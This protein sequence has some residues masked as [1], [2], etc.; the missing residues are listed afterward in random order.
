MGKGKSTVDTQSFNK[1]IQLD[2]Y[3]NIIKKPITDT[4]NQPVDIIIREKDDFEPPPPP[5]KGRKANTENNFAFENV[6]STIKNKT[7]TPFL[8]IP[9]KPKLQRQNDLQ[10]NQATFQ[11]QAEIKQDPFQ[12]PSPQYQPAVPQIQQPVSPQMMDQQQ[13]TQMTQNYIAYQAWI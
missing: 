11:R 13:Y 7:L 5:G 9:E 2:E 4:K 6:S 12:P 8:V 10:T 1:S 3:G